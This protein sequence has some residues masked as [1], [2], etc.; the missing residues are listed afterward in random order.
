MLRRQGNAREALEQRIGVRPERVCSSNLGVS[1]GRPPA[2]AQLGPQGAIRVDHHAPVEHASRVAGSRLTHPRA[3]CRIAHQP[4]E[5]LPR[6]APIDRGAEAGMADIAVIAVEADR[7]ARGD[8]RTGA[9]RRRDCR[10]HEPCLAVDHRVAI[11]VPVRNHHRQAGGHRLERRQ[12]E[13]LLDIVRER[14]EQIGSVPKAVARL[15]GAPIDELHRDRR[16]ES[17][18]CLAKGTIQCF[19]GEPAGQDEKN[20]RALGRGAPCRLEAEQHGRRVGF[21]VVA[22]PSEKERSN[23]GFVDAESRAPACAHGRALRG[24]SQAVAVNTKRDDR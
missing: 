11:A 21:G 8:L 13:G 4:A 17:G 16:A 24:L 14:H 20:A 3:Q 19:V 5:R 12:T 22:E 2:L 9:R 1:R 18:D 15:L 10:D 7:V 6:R 23:V